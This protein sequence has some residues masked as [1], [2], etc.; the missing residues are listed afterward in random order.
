MVDIDHITNKE[1]IWAP[2][3]IE[4]INQNLCLDC[5][6]FYQVGGQNAFQ[7]QSITQDN[8]QDSAVNSENLEVVMI[9]NPEQCADCT[10]CIS[11]EP[12]KFY[13]HYSFSV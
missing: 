2:Q 1:S 5:D 9:A 13:S 7:I 3:F 10:A 12:Q 4:E 8:Q 6:K 11:S